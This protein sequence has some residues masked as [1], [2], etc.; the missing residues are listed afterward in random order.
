MELFEP[1]MDIFI[2]F[3]LRVK[4]ADYSVAERIFKTDQASVLVEI[5]AVAQQ[6]F[7]L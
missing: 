3:A 7:I 4:A 1:A 2:A 6:I 5:S